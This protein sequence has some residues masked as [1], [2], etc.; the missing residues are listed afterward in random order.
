[1]LTF[2][3]AHAE[4]VILYAHIQNTLDS[5]LPV[6]FTQLVLDSDRSSAFREFGSIRKEVEDDLLKSAS[7]KIQS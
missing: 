2:F 3:F 5:I 4:T 7:V 6:S 1:M